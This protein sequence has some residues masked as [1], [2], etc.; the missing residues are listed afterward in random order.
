VNFRSA[1]DAFRAG[2]KAGVSS[3]RA[4]LIPKKNAAAIPAR[5]GRGGGRGGEEARKKHAPRHTFAEDICAARN[6]GFQRVRQF[7]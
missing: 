5:E 4:S 2:A 1:D 7:E 6:E 3:S